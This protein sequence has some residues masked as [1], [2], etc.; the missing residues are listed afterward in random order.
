M[1]KSSRTRVT[2]GGIEHHVFFGVEIAKYIF[3]FLDHTLLH[4]LK[5]HCQISYHKN[6]SILRVLIF[7]KNKGPGVNAL[8]DPLGF[9]PDLS[10]AHHPEFRGFARDIKNSSAN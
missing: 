1:G 7:S 6:Y 4:R 8:Q 2:M 9:L 3:E 10:I 5:N